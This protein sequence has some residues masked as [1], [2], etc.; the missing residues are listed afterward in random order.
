MKKLLKKLLYP[1]YLFVV[2]LLL[3]EGCFRFQL[4]D[5]YGTEFA[6]ANG[7]AIAESKPNVLVF[8]DSF[9]VPKEGYVKVLRDSLKGHNIINCGISGTGIYEAN[10]IAPRRIRAFPPK[11]VVYQIYVGNDLHNIR[12]SLNFSRL[13]FLKNLYYALSNK[14]KCLEYLNYRLGQWA[15]FREARA[16]VATA[17]QTDSLLV[18]P[19]DP[20]TYSAYEQ[21]LFNGDSA[22]LA[23]TVL[24]QAKRKADFRLLCKR[25]SQIS[26]YL[27]ANTPVFVLVIP[28]CSQLNSYYKS[29]YAQ[30]GIHIPDTAAFSTPAY[31]FVSQLDSAFRTH[32]Q[33]R[34]VDILP[35]LQSAD[36]S[37]HRM[38]LDNDF[39]FSGFGQQLTGKVLLEEMKSIR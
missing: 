12:K 13:S 22:L 33:F 31:P 7:E 37:R 21:Q 36:S 14:L 6:Y 38:F 35:F 19:F 26:A 30:M 17:N 16:Q 5:F 1:L 11:A 9:T 15:W 8:G 20:H 4:I 32:P 2:V 10:F 23:E 3:L 25:L 24:L 34:V 29:K 27:P 28:H 18:A 39:H